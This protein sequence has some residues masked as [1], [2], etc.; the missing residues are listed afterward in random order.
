MVATGR[1]LPLPP[2]RNARIVAAAGLQTYPA[3]ACRNVAGDSLWIGET[4][5]G[6]VQSPIIPLDMRPPSAPLLIVMD[7]FLLRAGLAGLL[8]ALIAAPLG[9]FIVWRR[10]AFLGAAV[11]H[12]GLLGVALALFLGINLVLGV[13]AVAFVIALVF[14][15]FESQRTLPADTLLGIL[16][17]VALAAGLLLTS[18]LGIRTDWEAFLF[19]DILTVMWPDFWAIGVGGVLVG[20]L[21]LWLWRPLLAVTVHEDLARVE[22]IDA[23]RCK[24]IFLLLVAIVTALAMKVVGI[25]LM[26]SLLVLPAS[27]ARPFA[28][29]PEQMALGAVLVAMVAVVL[30]LI[31]SA[32]FDVMAGPAMVLVMAALFLLSRLVHGAR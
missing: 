24:L 16:A 1:G 14:A 26:A 30:G 25:L 9:A 13:S 31:W 29:T 27:T 3:P 15:Y 21:L 12:G 23:G 4:E 20:G 5:H 22:G 28:A 10:M 7:D 8:I 32:L 11:A 17:H 19:G 2:L 18:A 6:P